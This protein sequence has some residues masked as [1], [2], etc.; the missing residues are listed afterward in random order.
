[1]CAIYGAV[2]WNI[3]TE[4]LDACKQI[5]N[6]IAAK[7]MERGRDGRGFVIASD[8][9]KAIGQWSVS[10]QKG[11]VEHPNPVPGRMNSG[12]L[13]GNMRAEPTTEFI[14]DKQE[15]DQQP[16]GLNGWWV[17]HNGTVANDSD[18]RTYEL[19]T[20]IDSAAI[21]E[22]LGQFASNDWRVNAQHFHR[23]VDSL[24]GSYAILAF[25]ESDPGTIY[26]ACNYRPIWYAGT[27]KGVWFASSE[28]YFHSGFPCRMQ[29]P[30]TAYAFKQTGDNDGLYV[31]HFLGRVGKPDYR[32][33]HRE[34]VLAVCSGGLDSTVAATWKVKQGCDVTLLHFHYGC[35]AN[36]AEAL[37]VQRIAKHLNIPYITKELPIWSASDSPLLRQGGEISSGVAGS[38][39]AHEWVP[40]RNLVMLAVATAIAEGQG[41]DTIVLGNNLEEAGAYPDNEQEFIHQFNKIL[42][43][44]VGTKAKIHVEMPVGHLMKHEIVALGHAEGAPMHL[45]WSCYRGGSQHCGRCGPCYMRRTAFSINNL[46]EVIT[47]KD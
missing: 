3:K 14:R 12:I 19:A 1:M 32:I 2:L 47:Y 25:H 30:Y 43:F 27:N 45:T 40:A 5:F 4:D 33:D 36:G 10:R 15:Y 9:N 35:Q 18:L 17:V 29:E 24:K 7:S 38:E 13:I 11:F 20:R 6:H 16:Y 22:Q 8:G 39:F 44:A 42:P 41:F 28:M 34:K 23:V 21:V 31:R 26:A 46:P 37:A